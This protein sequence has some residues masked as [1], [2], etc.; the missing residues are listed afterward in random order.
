LRLKKINST[1]L[2]V[3]LTLAIVSAFLMPAAAVSAAT[4]DWPLQLAGATTVN[5]TQAEFE[6]LAAANPASYTD[7]DGT[8]TGVALWR[9]IALVDDGDPATF[10]DALA[11]SGYSANLIGSDAYNKSIASATLAR[12]DNVVVANQLNGAPLPM[13][14]P[15]GT[16]V[17]YP[18]RS[19]GSALTSGQKVGGLV[20]IELL[21]LPVTAV[22]VTPASQ[23]VANGA[24]FTIDM[25]IDTDTASR[26]WQMN[27]N[28]DA[29]K[30]TANSV[31]E[32]SFLSAYAAANGGMT[33]PAGAATI[34][35]VAGTI[36][37]PGYAIMG[38]GTGGPTGTGTLCTI[39]FTAKTGID[40]FAS[41]TPT[42]VVI[43]DVTGTAIP[44]PVMIGGQV[45]IGNVPMP[46]L[47]VS[48]LSAA[49]VDDTT[50]TITY[51]ITNQGNAATG[52][53]TTSIV[54]DGGAP[55][56]VACPALAAGASDTQTTTAQT[57]TSGS[58]IIVVTT[59]SAGA[60]SESNEGNNT[61]TITYATIGANGNT[62][63]NSNIAA[64]LLLTVPASIDPWNLVQ[65]TNDITGSANMKCN[66]DW[67]LQVND[68]DTATSGHMTKWMLG[69]YVPATHLTAPLTV[70]CTTSVDLSGTPQTIVT[71][72]PAGQSGDSG[73]GLTISFHQPVFFADPVLTG[74]YS[75]HIVV[76]FTASVT[77]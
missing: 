28:F 66:T 31:T 58:D 13:T 44:G 49:K 47:V 23:A 50:Y 2:A 64:K 57:V 3:A 70:G 10:N 37:I 12:N 72:T 77:I 76:T 63:I 69:V 38:A 29:G 5:I 33:I 68:Q 65:G 74:G 53:C 21:N 18:L 73:Q 39:S 24:T 41:I 67:Q 11:S 75:Y 61:R 35:N 14:N 17:W 20:K 43:S 27:V 6:A 52:A 4:Q 8:W 51:T 42:G 19:V 59:D 45:A 30:L 22:S 71:G 26:G 32:G 62:S 60:V 46:D 48:A 36:T 40:D 7:A 54:I 15:A 56:T 25:N 16:K 9:L 55:M 1:L 34:D